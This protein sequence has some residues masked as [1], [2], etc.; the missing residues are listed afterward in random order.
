LGVPQGSLELGHHSAKNP[1]RPGSG[2]HDLL[3]G[4]YVRSNVYGVYGH[5]EVEPL[6]NEMLLGHHGELCHTPVAGEADGYA[7]GAQLRE[8]GATGSAA[9]T[10]L[11]CDYYHLIS[12]AYPCH[13]RSNRLDD[14]GKLVTQRYWRPDPLEPGVRPERVNIAAT[15][16]TGGYSKQRLSRAGPGD[17]YVLNTSFSGLATRFHE[18]LHLHIS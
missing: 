7:L 5:G 12:R 17:R 10:A 18:G 4:L 8:T 14:T 6:G 3:P 13:T 11:Y 15:D 2:H 1:Y 16:A 9:T